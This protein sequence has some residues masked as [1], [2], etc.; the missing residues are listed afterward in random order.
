MRCLRCG[1]VDRK[2]GLLRDIKI[3]SERKACR[4]SG[5]GKTFDRGWSSITCKW[6]RDCVLGRCRFPFVFEPIHRARS[7]FR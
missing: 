5:F 7:R 1:L 2:L 3:E 4:G 6:V